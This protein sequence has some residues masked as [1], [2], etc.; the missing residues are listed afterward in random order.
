MPDRRD[1]LTLPFKNYCIYGTFPYPIPNPSPHEKPKECCPYS[2]SSSSCHKK[3][4][5]KKKCSS[6]SSNSS[7][8]SSSDS[9]HKLKKCCKKRKCSDNHRKEHSFF[10]KND[11]ITWKN[12]RFDYLNNGTLEKPFLITLTDKLGHPWEN[13]IIGTNYSLAIDGVKGKSLYLRRN[14]RYYFIFRSFDNR[15]ELIYFTQDPAG[16]E[17][18]FKNKISNITGP[19]SENKLISLEITNNMPKVFYYQSATNKFMGGIIFIVDNY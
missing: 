19:F 1:A 4:K 6:S 12:R 8:S 10:K 11:N 3:H 9:C 18:V 2:E 15:N 7:S 13:K 14:N 16:G 17:Y 5:C